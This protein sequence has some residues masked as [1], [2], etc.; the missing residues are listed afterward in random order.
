MTI[1]KICVCMLALISMMVHSEES[2]LDKAKNSA[3][4]LWDK[5][6]TTAEEIAQTTTEKASE[7]G[8]KASDVG[9]KVSKKTKETGEVVWDKMQEVGAAAAE[10]A[11]NSASKIRTYVGERKGC[12]E[13]TV[14]C[15]KDKE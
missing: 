11:R 7:F 15:Y 2:S 12:D 4:N 8:K 10:G 9:K 13:D 1:L 5:T 14:F 3:A 6:K